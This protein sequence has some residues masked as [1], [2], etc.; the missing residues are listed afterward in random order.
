MRYKLQIHPHSIPPYS[1]HF[2]PQFDVLEWFDERVNLDGTVVPGHW[3]DMAVASGISDL[4]AA[5]GIVMALNRWG[6]RP[7]Y[8]ECDRGRRWRWN[9]FIDG[10]ERVC[11]EAAR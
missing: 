4:H 6:G 8:L 10:W 1:R 11:C 5:A 2:C 9:V 3:A 7:N